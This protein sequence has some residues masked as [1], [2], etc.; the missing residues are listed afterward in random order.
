MSWKDV[1]FDKLDNLINDNFDKIVENQ[2]KSFEAVGVLKKIKCK[3]CKWYFNGLKTKSK[4][5]KC[6]DFSEFKLKKGCK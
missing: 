4:C 5:R 6:I 2:N 1:N 3:K